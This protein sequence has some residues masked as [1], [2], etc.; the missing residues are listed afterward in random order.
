MI[1][2]VTNNLFWMPDAE[3]LSMLGPLWALVGTLV[4]LLIGAVAFGR[5]W[6]TAFGITLVGAL[7][8]AVLAVRGFDRVADG[9]WAGFAPPDAAPMLL[10]DQ[11]S[12]FFI[13]LMAVFLVLVGGLWYMGHNAPANR[14]PGRKL[15]AVEFFVLFVGSAFGMALMVSTTN[16]LM[17]LLAVEMASLPSY[18]IVGFRKHH[19][20]AAEASVKYVL[21]GAVTSAIMIYGTSLLYGQYGTLDLRVIGDQIAA[22][23]AAGPTTLMGVSL[24]ALMIGAAFK[25]SAVPFHFWCPDVFEGASIEVTTWLSVASK[26]AGLGLLLRIMTA[27]TAGFES[28]LDHEATCYWLVIAIGIMASVTCTVGNLSAFWQTNLKRLLAFSSVAHAGYML[29]FV[30]II[31]VPLSSNDPSVA[32]P[33]YSAFAA[34]L[35]VYLFMNLGAF[36]VVAMV[37]WSTGKETIDAFVG[38]GRRKPVLA[39]VMAICL[40]S[41]IGLPPMGGFLAKWWLLAALGEAKLWWLVLVAVFNTLISLYYYLRIIHAM[42]FAED[43]STEPI[44]APLAGQAVVALCALMILLTGTLW[45]GRLKQFTDR[46]A[47]QLYAV[48]RETGVDALSERPTNDSVDLATSVAAPARDAADEAHGSESTDVSDTR[49]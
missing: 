27:V 20:P 19:R 8:T 23:A 29:M 46:R 11:F 12:Y 36:G 34:Y 18:A 41:L 10:A 38:L 40:F 43:R 16:L 7:A 17:I 26:A 14:Q 6:R 2:T 37:Y 42:Y 21:F 15:D 28:P 39:A 13:F 45:A 4:A 48:G 32:H 44:S 9:H 25:V 35:V 47:R 31:G 33:V 1:A 30:A 5:N 49:E 24:F 3:T 22:H